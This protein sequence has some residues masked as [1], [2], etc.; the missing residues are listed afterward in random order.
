MQKEKL[1]LDQ[2]FRH[3]GLLGNIFTGHLVEEVDLAGSKAVVPTIT[4]KS[5]IYG[6]NTLVLE[7]DDPFPDGFTI[8]DIWA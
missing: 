4:G 8:G 1:S 5:W 3:Q 7:H 6:L 2:P